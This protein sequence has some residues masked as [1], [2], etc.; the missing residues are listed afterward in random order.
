MDKRATIGADARPLPLECTKF[1]EE[2]VVQIKLLSRLNQTKRL[3]DKESLQV[4]IKFKEDLK[5]T[6]DETEWNVNSI[7]SFGPNL[8]GPNILFNMLNDSNMNTVWSV[9][10]TLVKK[11]TLQLSPTVSNDDKISSTNLKEFE[12]SINFGFNLG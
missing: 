12:N 4:L 7:M 9:L 11:D 8:F 6:L 10:N 5:E 3:Q 2:S 1:L